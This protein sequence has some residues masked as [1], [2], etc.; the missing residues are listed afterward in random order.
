MKPAW[1][2]AGLP[3]NLEAAALDADLW[4]DLLQKSSLPLT[5]EDRQR[6]SRC[7]A[8]LRQLVTDAPPLL[9]MRATVLIAVAVGGGLVGLLV[10]ALG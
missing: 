3:V 5:V 7:R 1:D 8:T 2:N 4:L 9:A 6:L 10:G